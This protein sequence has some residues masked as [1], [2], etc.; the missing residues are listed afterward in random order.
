MVGVNSK[1][2]KGSP[3]PP[4]IVEKALGLNLKAEQ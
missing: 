4:T 3:V 2:E 1:K